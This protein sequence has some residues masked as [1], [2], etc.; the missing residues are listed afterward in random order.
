MFRCASRDKGKIKYHIIL[1]LFS[2]RHFISPLHNAPI[3]TVTTGAKVFCGHNALFNHKKN[4]VQSWLKKSFKNI[5]TNTVCLCS[6]RLL[7][8]VVLKLSFLFTGSTQPGIFALFASLLSSLLGSSFFL[9]LQ[10]K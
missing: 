1:S 7:I 8:T 4:T 10:P 9:L 2:N 3:K 5:K 6:F